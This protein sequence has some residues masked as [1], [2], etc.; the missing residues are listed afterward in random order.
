MK[1]TE[2][3]KALDLGLPKFVEAL[4]Q[5]ISN[6]GIKASG[7]LQNSLHVQK[8]NESAD[9]LNVAIVGNRYGEAVTLGRGPTVNSGPGAVKKNIRKW[10]DQKGLTPKDGISKDAMAFLIA[11]KIHKEGFKA[12]PFVKE[13]TEPLEP[14]FTRLL[15]EAIRQDIIIDLNNGINNSQQSARTSTSV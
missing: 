14:E 15:N 13:A 4:K 9:L 2:T 7:D 8:L 12:Q 6:K 10:I 1:F 5:A 3:I 11:R